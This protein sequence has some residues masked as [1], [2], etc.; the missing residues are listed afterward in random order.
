MPS[1]L[2]V[3]TSVKARPG[4]RPIEA[5]EIASA[6]IGAAAISLASF[7]YWAGC[8]QSGASLILFASAG[9]LAVFMYGIREAHRD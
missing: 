9:V 5:F 4:R 8:D 2:P 6:L 3:K 7:V 1:R